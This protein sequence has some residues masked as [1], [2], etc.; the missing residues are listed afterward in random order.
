MAKYLQCPAC[1]HI[2]KA[3]LVAHKEELPPTHFPA[4]KHY[5]VTG[6]YKCKNC[7]HECV[8]EYPVSRLSRVSEN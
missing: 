2:T 7:G 4:F 3:E 1:G 6:A 5:H 8:V